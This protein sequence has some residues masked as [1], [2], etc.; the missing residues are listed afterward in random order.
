M[1]GIIFGRTGTKGPEYNVLF[2]SSKIEIRAYNGFVTAEVPS[3]GDGGQEFNILA[4]Y[5]GV[6]GSPENEVG[7]AMDMTHPVIMESRKIDMTAPVLTEGGA[8]KFVLPSQFVRIEDAPKPKDSRVVIKSTPPQYIACIG[9]SGWYSHR[10]GVAQLKLLTRTIITEKF[11]PPFAEGSDE[12]T[13]EQAT[14]LPWCV[15]QY[16]PPFT[17]PWLRLNEVWVKLDPDQSERLRSLIESSAAASGE[18]K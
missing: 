9:F 6:F 3:N 7:Q 16:H 15:A 8:M 5:I 17:L 11:L 2:K 10:A 12:F 14:S 4:K 18:G 1:M 13:E